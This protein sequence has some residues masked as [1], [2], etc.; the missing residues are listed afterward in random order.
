MI[1]KYK[2]SGAMTK[3]LDPILLHPTLGNTGLQNKS[4]K[5]SVLPG[6]QRMKSKPGS[7]ETAYRTLELRIQITKDGSHSTQ[8]RRKQKY[9]FTLNITNM[10]ILSLVESSRLANNTISRKI[11][12]SMW[13]TSL[14]ASSSSHQ[15]NLISQSG[16]RPWVKEMP[17]VQTY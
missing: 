13:T 1:F 7:Q 5:L 4:L 9:S 12:E 2:P 6:Q 17:E 15:P 8:L 16:P 14:L 11:S 10:R 3:L